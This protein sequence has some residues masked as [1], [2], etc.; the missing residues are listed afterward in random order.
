MAVK[1]NLH[2][3]LRQHTGGQEAV[4]LEGKTVGECLENLVKQYPGL[5]P[6]IFEKTGGL[7]RLIEIYVNLQS[8]YSFS[9]SKELANS[10]FRT[11]LIIILS[12]PSSYHTNLQLSIL[13]MVTIVKGSYHTKSYI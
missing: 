11:P 9:S 2:A 8:A 5:E 10:S 4:E 6:S 13:C 3:T 1:V 12:A 7:S